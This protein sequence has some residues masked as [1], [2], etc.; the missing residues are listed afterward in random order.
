[1]VTLNLTVL[2]GTTCSGSIRSAMKL[3]RLSIL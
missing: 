1:V 3:R 2:P